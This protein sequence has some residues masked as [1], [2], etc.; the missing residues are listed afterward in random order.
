MALSV[1]GRVGKSWKGRKTK[2]EKKKSISFSAA[3][4]FNHS[5]MYF[6]P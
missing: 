4:H 2:D 1:G 6:P 5:R 3:L